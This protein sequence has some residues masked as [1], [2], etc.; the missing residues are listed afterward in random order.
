MSVCGLA[1]RLPSALPWLVDEKPLED[2]FCVF[3]GF[4]V[5]P[6]HLPPATS[7]KLAVE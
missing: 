5:D 1:R 4:C 6:R 7:M 3:R 2:G